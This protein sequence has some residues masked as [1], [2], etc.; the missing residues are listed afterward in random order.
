MEQDLEHLAV[1]LIL[2]P[3]V[4]I[5]DAKLLERIALE[6]FKPKNI[7]YNFAKVTSTFFSFRKFGS[8]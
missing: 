5:I 2:Q 8:S 3:L 7:W 4:G 1:E 6:K